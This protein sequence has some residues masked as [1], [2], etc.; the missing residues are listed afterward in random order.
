MRGQLADHGG[1]CPLLVAAAGNGPVDIDLAAGKDGI[2]AWPYFMAFGVFRLA[3]IAQGVY[4]RSLQG[5]ASSEDAGGYGAA[6]TV[7]SELACGIA[8]ISP[9]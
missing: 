2:E 4:R 7:L 6:V 3:A 1:G 8:G 5:N 9:R